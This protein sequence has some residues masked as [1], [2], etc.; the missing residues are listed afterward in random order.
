MVSVPASKEECLR[1]KG[2]KMLCGLSYCPIILRSK[3]LIPLRKIIPK[4]K[5]NY[6]GPS[7]PSIFV[8]RFGYPKVKIGPMAAVETD[9]IGIIDEPDQWKT[10]MSLEDIVGFR[11]KLLRFITPPVD[12][13]AATDPSRMMELTQEQVQASSPVNLE[14]KFNK[15]P[16]ISLSFDRFT[17]P[18]G[19]QVQV[20]SLQL[21]STPKIEYKTDRVVSD[22]DLYTNEAISQLYE[23]EHTVTQISRIFS[24]GLLGLKKNRRFVPTR[25]SITAVDDIIGNQLRNQI[26]DLPAIQNHLV[27]HNSYLDNDFW[28]LFIPKH[29]WFFDYH[30]AWKQKSAWNLTGKISKIYTDTEGPNGRKSYATNTVGGYYAARLAVQEKLIQ[31]KRKAAVLAFREVGEGYAIPL[32]V[33]QVRENMRHALRKEPLAFDS[34]KSSLQ[35]IAKGLTIP[36]IYY[37]NKSPLLNRTTLDQFLKMKK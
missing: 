5:E 14:I 10:N 28:V 3:A 32:G 24:S 8:G 31:M 30:E 26:R 18:M 27:F 20:E 2:G 22:T 15:K 17:Q 29:D 6:H 4:M 9:S 36:M 35:Y 1:C 19:G 21:A 11:A 34:L 7:P 13:K 12:V 33:W 25:W 37:Y 23:D 16:R